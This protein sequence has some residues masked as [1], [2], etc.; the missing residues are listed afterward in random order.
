MLIK[1]EVIVRLSRDELKVL[2]VLFI[3]NARILNKSCPVL[4]EQ[5]EIKTS[6]AKTHGAVY[7]MKQV[8]CRAA[9]P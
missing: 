7:L 3:E 6:D 1:Q 8:E 9:R 2:K 5:Y 4:K